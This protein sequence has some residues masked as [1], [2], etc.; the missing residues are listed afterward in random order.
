M[1]KGSTP[2]VRSK[3]I[4]CVLCFKGIH[5]RAGVGFTKLEIVAEPSLGE[6]FPV[7]CFVAGELRRSET[8]LEFRDF[9]CM[10]RLELGKVNC[11]GMPTNEVRSWG[12]M[13]G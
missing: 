8:C 7:V 13:N 11:A 10:C 5:C 6:S 9:S 2:F 1:S 4:I 12:G 3:H